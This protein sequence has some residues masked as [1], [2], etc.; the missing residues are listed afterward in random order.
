MTTD[1]RKM[2][3]TA[4]KSPEE[5]ES[6]AAPATQ[7][8]KHPQSIRIIDTPGIA[9]Q[10]ANQVLDVFLVNGHT[11]SIT[12]GAKRNIREATFGERETIIAVNARLTVD[13][14]AAEALRNALNKV[15]AMTKPPTGGVN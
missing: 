14:H 12:F 1:K 8:V 9:E 13:L 7:P 2:P 6:G 3:K 4:T 15:I 5:T 11:V 10:F